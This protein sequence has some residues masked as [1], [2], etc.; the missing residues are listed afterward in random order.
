MQIYIYIN[1]LV[2]WWIKKY[3]FVLENVIQYINSINIFKVYYIRLLTTINYYLV[4]LMLLKN[5][6]KHA[7][8]ITHRQLTHTLHNFVTG[9]KLLSITKQL[10]NMD[11]I[12]LDKLCDEALK[13]YKRAAQK[14]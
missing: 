4:I 1:I 10:V 11:S 12:E 9:E 5:L 6:L 3:R 13:N 8:N 2:F 7:Q 14:K